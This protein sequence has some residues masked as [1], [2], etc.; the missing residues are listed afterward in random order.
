M[1]RSR[2]V[3]FSSMVV[4]AVGALAAAALFFLDGARAAVGPLP[5]EGLA[6]PSDTRF[7]VGMDVR[8]FAASPFYKKY[9]QARAAVRP[10]ALRE[11]QE[12]TG[13]NPERDVDQVVI[14]GSRGDGR[15][16]GVVLVFGRFD[17]TRIGRLLETEGKG[18][19]W[20]TVHGAT[21]YLFAEGRRGA[22]ALAFLDDHAVVLGSQASVVSVLASRASG[23]Q[24]LRGNAALVA[25]LERVRPGATLWMVGDQTLLANIPKAIPAPG[26][27]GSGGSALVSLPPLKS[28]VVTAELDPAIAFDATGEAADEA[29]AK[30]LADVV[31]GFVALVQIQASQ[32]PELSALA[33][34]VSVTTEAT[35]VRVSGRFPYD[36]LD[37]LQP[38]PQGAAPSTPPTR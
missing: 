14:A 32:K 24:S 23:S 28:L 26:A 19:T 3:V 22:G 20:K 2:L 38:N 36:L 11:L 25:L 37:A 6:L 27:P 9:G 5:A 16:A 18:T 12:K 7:V 29:A 13:V 34:A 21:V 1:T 4:V 33:S 10:E 8:R 31:R 17:R 35:K 15:E 30:S